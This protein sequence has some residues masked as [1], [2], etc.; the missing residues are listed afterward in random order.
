M[1]QILGVWKWSGYVPKIL[2]YQIDPVG[3]STA[4]KFKWKI[5]KYPKIIIIPEVMKK[6][7]VPVAMV[8]YDGPNEQ[9]S[10][11]LLTLIGDNLG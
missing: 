2:I 11:F 8:F 9:N 1:I 3:I 5:W 10:I 4:R 6:T 7:W